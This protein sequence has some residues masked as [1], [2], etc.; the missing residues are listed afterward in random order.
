MDVRPVEEDARGIVDPDRG[1]TRFRLERAAPGPALARFVDRYWTASWDL[2]EPYT[3]PVLAHPVV[4]LVFTGGTATLHG[5]ATRVGR[6]RLA[7]R[8]RALGVMFRPAGFR[9][10][11]D[12]PL[13]DLVD[14]GLPV[15]EV[16]PGGAG[17]ER[18]AARLDP[19]DPSSAVPLTALVEGF[20]AGLAPGGRHPAEDTRDIAERI[21]ADPSVTG[22]AGLAEREGLGVRG[23]QRRFSDHLGLGPKTVIRRYRFYEAAER[24]RL[25]ERPDWGRLAAD[26]GFSDQS[27]LTR[28]FTAVIGVPPGRYAAGTRAAR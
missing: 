9:P 3:Q 7:G 25:G 13:S 10:F 26:L 15:G 11:S 28:E 1:L 24:A 19:A 20:L 18:E 16:L 23:L 2:R 12:R 5:P 6:R 14:T 8:G 4:N 22:V 27:H 17:L 21:A